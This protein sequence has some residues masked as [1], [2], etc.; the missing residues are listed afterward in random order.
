L[1]EQEVGAGRFRQDLFYRLNVIRVH[2]APLR[3]R[4]EDIPILA[5]HF[6]RKHGT[7]QNKKLS[8]HPDALRWI[9]RRS[10]PGNVRELENVVE[11]AV[12][13]AAGSQV[14]I[15]DLAQERVESVAADHPHSLLPSLK[16]GFDL[17]AWLAEL[18]KAMVLKALEETG[19]SQKRAARLLGASF[20]S[21]RYRLR[22]YGL[23]DAEGESDGG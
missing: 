7:L 15:D 16:E 10:Y 5:E 3:E 8:F 13:F 19:G 12:A 4:P 1:L 20:H 17:D 2:L 9:E 6:L 22:K 14:T 21:F 23:A 18:E 11:R